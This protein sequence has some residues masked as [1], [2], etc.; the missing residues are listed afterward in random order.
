MPNSK[1]QPKQ[2]NKLFI[3][4]HVAEAHGPQYV[5]KNYLVERRQSFAY[6]AF[7]FDYARIGHAKLSVYQSSGHWS[8]KKGHANCSKGV[9]SWLKDMLTL[10]RWGWSTTHR[11]GVFIGINNLNTLVGLGLRWFGRC[12][13]VIYYVIDYTPRRFSNRWLNSIY[14][15]TAKTA[16]K[17]ADMVWSLSEPMRQIHHQ[18]GARQ[19]TNILV[20]IGIDFS[21]VQVVPLEKIQK[22]QLVVIST[23]FESK[24][25]QLVIAAMPALPQARL[26]VVGTG[27]YEQELKKLATQ[28]GV[29][30]RVTFY[31]CLS[32]Q[33][34]MEVLSHSM[35]AI[36]PYQ[37]DP[38]NYSYYADPAK[39]KEY[40]ACGIPVVITKVPWIAQEIAKK[41]MGIAI[42]DDVAQ[43]V[44]A[45]KKLMKDQV[46]WQQCREHALDYVQVLSW[47]TIFDRAFT[48][49][50]EKLGTD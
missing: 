23:L 41:P 5:L 36:A 33:G 49:Y 4:T 22:N 21:E 17:R 47:E 29:D 32:R 11:D 43:L 8:E 38:D 45:C 27:P 34:L 30:K 13:H 25:V 16:A 39:P 3:A 50:K 28:L 6:A 46:F 24:G 44:S 31:G 20:P 42:D 37:S 14:Q 15:W 35:I 26:S 7:P 12:R 18:F 2:K 19:E 48:T 40:L 1:R 10:W 9:L